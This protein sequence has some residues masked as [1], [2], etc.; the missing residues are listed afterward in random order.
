MKGHTKI[1]EMRLQRLRPD[2]VFLNDYPCKTDWFEYQE[3]ATVCTAGD[4]LASM[5]LRFLV[6]CTVSISATS[7]DRAKAIFA[8]AKDAGAATVA[9]VHCQPDKNIWE[10]SGWCE[11]WRKPTYEALPRE[12]A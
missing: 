1:I 2:I 6:G 7:E 3:H 4:S 8:K 10:Q 12:V 11:V 9:A 5:D